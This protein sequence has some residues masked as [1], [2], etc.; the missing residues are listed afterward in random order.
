MIFYNAF[1]WKCLDFFCGNSYKTKSEAHEWHILRFRTHENAKDRKTYKNVQKINFSSRSKKTFI[2]QYSVS[3]QFTWTYLKWHSQIV[4]GTVVQVRIARRIRTKIQYLPWCWDCTWKLTE[5]DDQRTVRYPLVQIFIKW[6]VH[7]LLFQ[8]WGRCEDIRCWH[9]HS[10]D[11][12]WHCFF[13]FFCP[14]LLLW[15]VGCEIHWC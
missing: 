2:L 15:M 8:Q 14:S 10:F 3:L 6:E 4:Q 11:F 5:S 12:I 1:L 7:S 13:L 9:L